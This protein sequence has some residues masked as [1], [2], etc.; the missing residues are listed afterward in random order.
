MQ[1][2]YV[3]ECVPHFEGCTSISRAA[4]HGDGNLL[5][6]LLMLPCAALQALHWW[7]VARWVRVRHPDPRAGRTIPAFGLVAAFA[8]TAYTV[9]LGADDAF[10]GWMRRFGITFYFGA[11]FLAILAYQRRLLH[12]GTHRAIVRAMLAACALMLA[13]GVASTIASAMVVDAELKNR[14][15]NV[16]EWQLGALLTLWFLLNAALWWRPEHE[17]N[18]RPAP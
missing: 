15:E 10:Y 9:A 16:L 3:P 17:S 12:L 6:K 11:T 2:G 18:V 8:L 1:A 7:M 5:F 14:V 13:L 4:R